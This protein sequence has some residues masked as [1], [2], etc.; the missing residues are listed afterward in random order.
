M[1]MAW[2]TGILTG[3]MVLLAALGAVGLAVIGVAG[4]ETFYA[5][6]SRQAVMQAHGFASEA[7]VSAAIGL[8]E[9]QQ[10]ALGRD[11]A[12]Y[13]MG[14]SD[15]LPTD[16]LN[17]KESRHMMDVRSILT[18]I[19]RMSRMCLSLAAALAVVAAWT[20]A[21]LR[22]RMLPRAI[23]VLAAVA[24]AALAA[25]GAA[26]VIRSAGFEAAFVRMHE[27][28]F[29]NDLW[30]LDPQTDILIRMMPQVLFEQAL[31]SVVSR[32]LRMLALA[33]AMLLAV[34]WTVSGM[35]RRHLDKGEEA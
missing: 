5:A 26:L 20:G 19:D 14:R 3:L 10:E 21:R 1:R 25:V 8:D 29:D 17:E 11:L 32:A 28:L 34:E 7:E 12:A 27:L 23:G 35:I 16:I 18:A 22:R 30:L 13:V 33:W 2:I 4:D 31:L 15:A 24:L 6:Q 9:A